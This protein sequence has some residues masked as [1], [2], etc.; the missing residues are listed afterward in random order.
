MDDILVHVSNQQEHDECLIAVLERL[1]KYH[2]TLNKEKCVFSTSSVK[3]LGHVIDQDGIKPDPEKVQAI[4]DMEEPKLV[5]DLRHFPG[6][7]N[8][9]SKF[10]PDLAE[11]TKPLRDLLS[12]KNEWVWDQAHNK[13]FQDIK[14]RL[15]STPVLSLYNLSNP[16]KVSADASSYGIGAVLLQ[17]QESGEW[18]L[19]AYSSR[20]L[21]ST[22]QKYAQI[23]KEALSVTWACE[24]FINYLF[25]MD[26]EIET[27][28]KPL[29]SLLGGKFIDELPLWIQHFRMRLM[30]FSYGISH[31]PGKNLVIADTLSQAPSPHISTA[32]HELKTEVE[33]YVNAMITSLP[34]TDTKLEEIKSAQQTDPTCKQLTQFCLNG[35][36]SSN[37]LSGE[38]KCYQSVSSEL[39]TRRS[40]NEK[41]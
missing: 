37:Q 14:F 21:T 30:K 4:Q 39:C 22:E 2:G 35:W 27:D 20:S 24:R 18:K 10:S 28:H 25:G 29:I 17:K 26:F 19:V 1:Q 33:A 32:D 31:I 5:S 41:R 23:E 7:C 3:F 11:T 15:S 13:S 9:L 38:I 8:Q 12:K 34:A 36:P 40:V 16:T 6:M